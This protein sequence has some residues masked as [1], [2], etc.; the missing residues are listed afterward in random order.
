MTDSET[1][2]LRFR[3]T[4]DAL[5]LEPACLACGDAPGP[6][7]SG[8]YCARCHRLGTEHREFWELKRQ[9]ILESRDAWYEKCRAA[10]DAE[11][12]KQERKP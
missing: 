11:K 1:P 9:E 10:R 4:D 8:W 6:D 12:E 2:G 3:H 5:I 7:G